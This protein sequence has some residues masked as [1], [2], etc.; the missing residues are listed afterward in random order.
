MIE[1]QPAVTGSLKS[2]IYE[3]ILTM[4]INGD[5]GMEELLSE[6][7]LMSMFD[8]SRA[9]VREALIELCRDDILNNIPRAG[10]QIVR[11]SEKKMRDAFQLREILELE[12]LRLAFDRMSVENIDELIGIASETDLLRQQGKT[13]ES[14][15]KKMKLND[16]F[17]LKLGRLSGNSL[18]SRTLEE[19]FAL[20]RRGLAQ[21]MI[22]EYGLPSPSTTF[23]TGLAT[24]LKEHNFEE[25]YNNL[26]EDILCYKKNVWSRIL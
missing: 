3:K 24:A 14:L 12:G 9:P 26:K 23:H 4:I 19:T 22:D 1:N 17:H 7:R 18:L 20:I 16:H 2:Q 5:F 10:Y 11:I 8:V 25:A 15:E 21:V 6:S 13:E